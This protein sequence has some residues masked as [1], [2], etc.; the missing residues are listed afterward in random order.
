MVP[1]AAIGD[2][3]ELLHSVPIPEGVE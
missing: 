1:V 2:L 3:I